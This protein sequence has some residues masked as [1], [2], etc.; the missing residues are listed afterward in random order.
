MLRGTWYLRP[1]QGL[2]PHPLHWKHG[3]LTTTMP[4][5]SH[6]FIFRL[7]ILKSVIPAFCLFSFFCF[8]K[9]N[10]Y[11][12]FS[13]YAQ[14]PFPQG[15]HSFPKRT[16]SLLRWL[17][18]LVALARSEVALC[19]VSLGCLSP[20]TLYLMRGVW[21]C[22]GKLSIKVLTISCQEVN[23]YIS[24][25]QNSLL[26]VSQSHSLSCNQISLT[27]KACLIKPS[28]EYIPWKWGYIN[29]LEF[30]NHAL[31]EWAAP[32]SEPG[33]FWGVGLLRHS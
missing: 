29:W 3:V 9:E 24:F 14:I 28:V 21:L 23:F 13:S 31:I 26:S 5:K 10:S 17:M 6:I 19:W 20:L 33:G 15:D 2:R 30:L 4:G 7:E 8:I 32:Y 25:Q 11:C 12:N 1:D 27:D 16:H 22:I 18:L